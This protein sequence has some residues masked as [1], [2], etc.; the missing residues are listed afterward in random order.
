MSGWA[1]SQKN[2]KLKASGTCRCPHCFYL[3]KIPTEVTQAQKLKTLSAGSSQRSIGSQPQSFRAK[4]VE[5]ASTLGEE[6]L[7]NSCPVCHYIFERGQR[8]VQCGNPDC[9]TLYHGECFK[10]L[11]NTQCKNCGSQNSEFF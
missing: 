2:E 6:A 7:Y 11:N 3:L 9:H 1:N 10:K 8:V 4:I 5:D